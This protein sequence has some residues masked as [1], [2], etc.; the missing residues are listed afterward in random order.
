MEAALHVTRIGC[1][2]FKHA[3]ENHKHKVNRFAKRLIYE[4]L[5]KE[6]GGTIVLWIGRLRKKPYFS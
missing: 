3:G 1:N 5:T 6:F 2:E 4:D